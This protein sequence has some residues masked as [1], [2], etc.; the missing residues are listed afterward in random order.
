MVAARA[1]SASEESTVKAA[2]SPSTFF[3]SATVV[4]DSPTSSFDSSDR[5]SVE[6]ERS[7]WACWA[8]VQAG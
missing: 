2:Y 4:G 1:A 8:A 3:T 5:G 7:R 6:E